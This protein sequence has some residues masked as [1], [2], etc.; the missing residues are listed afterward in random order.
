M[1]ISKKYK[2]E[3]VGEE[4]LSELDFE[5]YTELFGYDWNETIYEKEL[6]INARSFYSEG[7]PL[8]IDK[9][10]KILNEFKEKGA[11]HVA[12]NNHVDHIGYDL[13][14]IIIGESS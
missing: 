4:S 12:L 3:T 11:T 10:I 13:E 9:L 1:D 7:V 8:K 2:I 6:L 5:L 14:A